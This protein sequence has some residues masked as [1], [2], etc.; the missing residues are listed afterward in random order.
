MLLHYHHYVSLLLSA[1]KEAVVR[2]RSAPSANVEHT[3]AK[4]LQAL[5]S[6]MTSFSH[7]SR[8]RSGCKDVPA[9]DVSLS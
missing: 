2:A 8:L 9:A 4:S 5:E 7:L 3:E 6:W 1:V